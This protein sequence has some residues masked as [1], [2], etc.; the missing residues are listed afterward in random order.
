MFFFE[1]KVSFPFYFILIFTFVLIL[2]SWN[3]VGF[4]LELCLRFTS[5]IIMYHVTENMRL[6]THVHYDTH[7]H[8]KK[9]SWSWRFFKKKFDVYAWLSI[10]NSTI[11][12]KWITHKPFLDRTPCRRGLEDA[13]GSTC[14]WVRTHFP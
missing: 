14:R 9:K 1:K 6:R 7:L 12:F 4:A 11:I 13:D 3:K 5:D 10:Y 2:P 8:L